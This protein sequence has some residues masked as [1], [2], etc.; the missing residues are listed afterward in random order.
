MCSLELWPLSERISC[1]SPKHLLR[2]H[3]HP[4]WCQRSSGCVALLKV[5]NCQMRLVQVCYAAGRRPVF[6]KLQRV[7]VWRRPQKQQFMRAPLAL[8]ITDWLT[9]LIIAPNAR[10]GS[11]CVHWNTALAGSCSLS[12]A[13]MQRRAGRIARGLANGRAKSRSESCE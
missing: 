4:C 1:Q 3:D 5:R 7:A 13:K 9:G 12:C 8:G 11:A 10:A 6:W 2:C